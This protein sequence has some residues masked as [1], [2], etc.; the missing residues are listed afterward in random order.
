MLHGRLWLSVSMSA[1]IENRTC[2]GEYQSLLRDTLEHGLSFLKGLWDPEKIFFVSNLGDGEQTRHVTLVTS[3][4][5]PFS[6]KQL[7]GKRMLARYSISSCLKP[8]F[9]SFALYGTINTPGSP[10]Q[11]IIDLLQRGSKLI[12]ASSNLHL[13]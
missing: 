8:R 10:N 2:Y 9:V 7:Y 1:S 4:L 5:I 6:K 13:S 12:P 11:A 3:H